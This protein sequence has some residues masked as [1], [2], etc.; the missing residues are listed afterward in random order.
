[1]EAGNHPFEQV[2]QRLESIPGVGR[3]TAELL[4]S[5]MGTGMSRFPGHRHLAFWSLAR[6]ESFCHTLGFVYAEAVLR[7]YL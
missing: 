2:L 3:R 4:L 6:V 1:M 5:E 7:R